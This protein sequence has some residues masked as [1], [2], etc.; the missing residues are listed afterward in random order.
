[1]SAR[2][3]TLP[4]HSNQISEQTVARFLS[5]YQQGYEQEEAAFRRKLPELLATYRGLFVA[6]SGGEIIDKDSDELSLV[7]RVSDL[8]KDRF[9]F[10]HRV[11]EFSDRSSSRPTEGLSK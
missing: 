1:M 11:E 4:T 9:F 10:I 3:L 8:P 2:T 6:L 5:R 7:K